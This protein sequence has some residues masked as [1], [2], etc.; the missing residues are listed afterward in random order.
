MLHDLEDGESHKGRSVGN[1]E[2]LRTALSQ[3]LA[4]KQ[5]LSMTIARNYILPKPHELRNGFFLRVS[6]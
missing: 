5:D 4:R 2:E 6:R 3:R 1:L